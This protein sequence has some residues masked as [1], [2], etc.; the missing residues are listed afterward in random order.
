MRRSPVV[1]AITLLVVTTLGLTVSSSAWAGP[2]YSTSFEGTVGSLPDDWRVLAGETGDPGWRMDPFGEYRYSGT[3]NAV[4]DFTGTFSNGQPGSSMSNGTVRAHFRKSTGNLTGLAARIQDAGNLYHARLY[5]STNSL[6]LYRIGG[7][8]GTSKLDS[9]DVSGYDIGET[10]MIEMTLMETHITAR[11]FDQFG[12]AVASVSASDGSFASG[13]AG[14]RGSNPSAWEDFTIDAPANLDVDVGLDP[15]AGNDND[16]QAGFQSF[17]ESN[18]GGGTGG[19]ASGA[20][21]QWF[22]S[23]LGNDN[24]VLVNLAGN[25]PTTGRMGFRDRGNTSGA[26]DDLAEDFVFNLDGTRLN[27]TLGS[28]KPGKYDITTYHHDLQTSISGTLDTSVDDARGSGQPKTSGVAITNGSATPGIGSTRFSFYSDGVNPVVVHIDQNTANLALLNGFALSP[29]V[30]S[31]RVDFALAGSANDVQDG[32]V[33]FSSPGDSGNVQKGFS[34][35]LGVNGTVTV[36]LAA[37][38]NTLQWRDR[39]DSTA[40]ELA[41]VAED[42]VFDWDWIELTLEGL[43][44]STYLLTTYHQDL[45][46][47]ASP[48]DID[49]W[50]GGGDGRRAVSGLVQTVSGSG[51]PALA[52]FLIFSDGSPVT[53]RFTDLGTGTNPIARLNGF[54]LTAVVPEPSTFALAV[55]GLCGLALVA[56]R[57]RKR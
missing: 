52:S 49:V 34:S 23:D 53:I 44:P 25:N 12:A 1:A 32:F 46:H 39:G 36:G 15:A 31:L 35:S 40:A 47:V 9:A 33:D 14:V 55:L 28:L 21:E 11:L 26:L 13:T 41:D 6:E 19:Y 10:W 27:L 38:D 2:L 54:A 22:D 30:E 29:A 43:V 56:R 48:L 37:P 51:N 8:G 17:V 57:R 16:V 24:R 4:S 18:V 20:K 42:F 45:I 3:G 50:D 7:T 5:G